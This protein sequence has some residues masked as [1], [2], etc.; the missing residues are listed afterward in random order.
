[1][2]IT[3]FKFE[4]LISDSHPNSDGHST[5]VSASTKGNIDSNYQ[6]EKSKEKL[7]PETPPPPTYSEEELETAKQQAFDKGF[8]AGKAEG[9]REIDHE[10][11]ILREQTN[12]ILQSINEQLPILLN[13]QQEFIA[14]KQPE[15]GSLVLNCAGRIA[16]EALRKDPISD[17][18]SMITE[19]LS[20]LMGKQEITA[21]V[22]PKLQTAL[23]E[24]FGRKITINADPTLSPG[25]CKLSW[26][27]GESVR[28]IDRIWSEIEAIIDRYFSIEA[29]NSQ[30]NGDGDDTATT[31]SEEYDNNMIDTS[32]TAAE[33]ENN[34]NLSADETATASD[35]MNLPT[36][37]EVK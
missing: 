19:C 36:N 28:E 4:P 12:M 14:Q 37:G 24:I 35:N 25:D 32:Q 29:N 34:L 22:H 1:M 10:E 23:V 8:A 16:L 30:Y 21:S 31:A 20:K 17:I 3:P 11:Q 26:G 33:T 2:E 18:E 15:I 9:K 13:Q 5:A 6:T 27:S 7:E